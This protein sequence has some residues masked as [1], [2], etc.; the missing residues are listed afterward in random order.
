MRSPQ[1]AGAKIK[2]GYN[3]SIIKEVF[4]NEGYVTSMSLDLWKFSTQGPD[5]FFSSATAS[6]EVSR[7]RGADGRVLT[8]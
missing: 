8:S 5:R 3:A 7:W 6:A 4:S 1:T 2:T